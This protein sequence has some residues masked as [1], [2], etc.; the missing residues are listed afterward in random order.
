MVSIGNKSKLVTS[1]VCQKCGKC[2]KIFEMSDRIDFALR[3]MWMNNKRIKVEDTDFRWD[4]G[5]EMKLITFK[6]PCSQLEFRDGKY[7]CKAWNKE[8]PDFCNTY[9]DHNFYKYPEWNREGII[10]ELEEVRK[11]CIGLRNVS[12]DDVIKMLKEHRKENGN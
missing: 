6:F 9:P 12:V 11:T 10:K 5:S 4:D 1:E 7:W 2:C 8:R 3:F